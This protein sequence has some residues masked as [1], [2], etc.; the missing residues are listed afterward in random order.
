MDYFIIEGQL[1]AGE[2][3]GE[4]IGEPRGTGLNKFVYFVSN[5]PNGPWV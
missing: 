4:I 3:E 1:D 5:Q 2:V